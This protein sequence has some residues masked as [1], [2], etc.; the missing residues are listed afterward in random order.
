MIATGW[1]S[2]E[3]L[4]AARRG[5]PGMASAVSAHSVRQRLG[6]ADVLA[7]AVGLDMV[8]TGWR[9]TVDKLSRPGYQATYSRSSAGGQGRAIIDHLKK[10]DMDRGAERLLDSTGWLSEPL[11]L[12]EVD[13]TGNDTKGE[14]EALPE[15]LATAEDEVAAD[16]DEEQPHII[17]AE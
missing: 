15:F 6:Q 16:A 17:A 14:A 9:P 2:R 3:S 12:V 11:R 4:S 7:R 10:C 5:E 13:A 1:R 8:A